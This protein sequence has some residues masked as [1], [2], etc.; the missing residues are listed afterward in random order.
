LGRSTEAI[1]DESGCLAAEFN[2]AHDANEGAGRAFWET[3]A[4]RSA[5]AV[6]VAWRA[7]GPN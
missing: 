7:A 1:R 3:R 2:A 4:D 5:F 6:K